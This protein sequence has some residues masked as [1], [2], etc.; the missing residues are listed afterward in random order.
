[1]LGHL[2]FDPMSRLRRAFAAQPAPRTPGGR[3]YW[4][5]VTDADIDRIA[6]EF[7]A[8]VAPYRKG[9]LLIV[10]DSDRVEMNRG[11][12]APDPLRAH[13]IETLRAG[14]AEVID[15]APVFARYVRETGYHL[16][17]SP[18]DAHWNARATKLVAEAV[19]AAL[20]RE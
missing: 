13:L 8:R 4:A 6:S 15:L 16:E 11:E 2:R 10:L 14:G 1:M 5:G 12:A 17:I 18:H 20:A 19:A 3:S 9:R 7:F